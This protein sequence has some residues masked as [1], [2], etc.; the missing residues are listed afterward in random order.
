M[1]KMAARQ[2]GCLTR[3]AEV[4]WKG[5]KQ[6]FV[7]CRVCEGAEGVPLGGEMQR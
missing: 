4:K 6:E 7:A 5:L 1:I 3:T 2:V